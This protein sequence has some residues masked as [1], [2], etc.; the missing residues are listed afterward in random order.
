MDGKLYRVTMPTVTSHVRTMWGVV[1]V[2]GI[3]ENVPEGMALDSFRS[4]GYQID[5]QRPEKAKAEPKEPAAEQ[6]AKPEPKKPAKPRKPRA[7]KT[8]I[9]QDIAEHAKAPQEAPKEE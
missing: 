9:T 6:P 2:E 1:F 8:P 5:E 4:F 7:A 3:A